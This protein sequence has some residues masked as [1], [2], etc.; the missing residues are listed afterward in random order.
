VATP[1][2]T[3]SPAA[4]PTASLTASAPLT[5]AQFVSAYLLERARAVL[6]G[7]PFSSLR[8][9]VLAAMPWIQREKLL[10]TG[11]LLSEKA[12]G[13]TLTGVDCQVAVTRVTPAKTT[14]TLWARVE[15]SVT[16]T[17]HWTDADG[18]PGSDT[19]RLTHT[20]TIVFVSKSGRRWRVVNDEYA[21]PQAPRLLTVARASAGMVEAAQTSLLARVG[22]I[23][24]IADAAVVYWTSQRNGASFDGQV[25]HLGRYLNLL[26]PGSPDRTIQEYAVFGDRRE[27]R[28]GAR[29]APGLALL[30]VA[31]DD[32]TVN[33]ARTEA[34]VHGTCWFVDSNAVGSIK[35]GVDGISHRSL[36]LRKVGGR[37]LVWRDNYPPILDLMSSPVP[38][39]VLRQQLQRAFSLDPR[40]LFTVPARVASPDAIA[41]IES[42]FAAV[43][44][45][46]LNGASRAAFVWAFERPQEP[47]GNR[48]T[49]T[50]LYLDVAFGAWGA[51]MVAAGDMAPGYNE[52]FFLLT[53]PSPYDAWH[54]NGLY[55]P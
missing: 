17:L 3:P 28:G 23:R 10:A 8:R 31:I 20:V 49:S 36:V 22:S 21:D 4:S 51:N 33:A 50:R 54:V 47:D 29:L 14:E 26:A 30:C 1:S 44:P 6:P 53:R 15:A 27:W 12:H 11:A 37:W 24:R 38:V 55:Y 32:I 52:E 39:A 42:Y 41:A 18:R 43:D 19:R 5:P 40:I 46:M 2:A 16:T 34:T 35:A 7:E 45:R 48:S 25:D 13:H 9:Y